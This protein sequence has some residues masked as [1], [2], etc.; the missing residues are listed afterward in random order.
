V[1][2]RMDISER[3]VPQDGRIKLK[4]SKSRAIDFRVNS[5]PLQFGEKIVLR[6]LDPASAQMGLDALGFE[7]EQRQLYEQ[8]LE[9]PQGMILVTGPTGSGKTVSLYT[10]LNALNTEERNISTAEDPVEINIDGINQVQIN[11]KVG[12]TFAEALRSFLRQDP[13]VVMVGEIR[14]LETAEIS[15]KAAQTGHLVLST[16]HTNSATETL[17]R[18]LNMGVATFNVATSVSLII[19]QRLARKLCDSCKSPLAPLPEAIVAEQGL[20]Q[21]ELAASE[22]TL[23]GAQGCEQ[24]RDGYRGRIGIYE[25]LAVTERLAEVIMS[26]ASSLETLAAAKAEG[27]KTLRHNALRKV[28]AGIISL[29]EAN[30]ITRQ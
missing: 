5:L 30:R 2:S 17:T 9:R 1:M 26:G 4:L 7:P 20:D 18:L 10:G 28:A 24:C 23:F 22:F 6:I 29:E 8:A 11:L 3:R 21:L 13:D 16:L 19:A 25:T 27:F 14:D 15:I 12:L